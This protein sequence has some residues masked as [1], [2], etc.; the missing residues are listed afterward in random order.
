M[1]TA[2]AKQEDGKVKEIDPATAK[3]AADRMGACKARLLLQQPFYGCLV[4]MMDFVREDSIPTMATDGTKAYYNP[5]F[6]MKIAEDEV[7]GV[8]LH[9]ISHCI[10]MHCTSKRR[11][12]R[13]RHRWNIATDYAINLEIKNMNYKLPEGLL[14]DDKYREMNAEQIYDKITSEQAAKLQTF[15]I[16]IED[17]D[18][19]NW[20]D[21]EDKIITAYE[22]S[23]NTKGR[24]ELPAGMKRWIEKMRKSKVNWQR[25]FWKY[26][27]QALSK[28]D[29]SYT[30]VNKRFLGQ[31]I[32]LPDLRSHKIGNVVIAIDTSG[33]IGKEC[34]EQFAAE[35]A[36]I[37]HLVEEITAIT[38]DAAV[39]EVVKI[40]KFQ[41]FMD[42]LHFRGGG[43]T[44][45]KPVFNWIKEHKL[46][47]EL[48]VCLTDMYS[49][50]Q[51]IKRPGYPVLW[52]S[53]SEIDKAPFGDVIQIPNDSGGRRW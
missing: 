51:D 6:V 44:S 39:Q 14:L 21:M 36:K 19:S 38:C 13:E 49:D 7:F 42:K 22:M 26:V 50:Q 33:S 46:E 18:S 1:S 31:D 34:V 16:H 27:G 17:A 11:L 30:R 8:L 23:K 3:S 45:H 28:D 25:V 24:G 2:F 53:T 35:I 37:G 40:S 20:D 12:N 15:D 29:Y 47:P 9:E 43:G 52:V 41:N 4:S 5:E 32:Y 48:L 10:Y